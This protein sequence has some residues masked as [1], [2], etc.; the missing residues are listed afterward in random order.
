M[1]AFALEHHYDAV[2]LRCLDGKTVPP[3]LS[4]QERHRL[5]E[6]FRAVRIPIVCVGTS[7]RFASADVAERRQ[8]EHQVEQYIELASQWESP[9]VRVFGGHFPE[10]TTPEQAIQRVAESLSR[11]AP[12]AR[13]KGITLVLETHDGFSR[14]E[15]VYEVLKRVQDK[16]VRAC[17]DFLHPLRVGEPVE[18]TLALLKG[19]VAHTHAKD[20]RPTGEGVWIAT[21][22]GEGEIPF[23]QIVAGLAQSGFDGALSLEWE[24]R[25]GLAPEVVLAHYARKVRQYLPI[26][27]GEPGRL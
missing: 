25:N 8:N 6:T 12:K 24:G 4:A 9:L 14:G 5:Q 27:C 3:D 19:Y 2:E 1:A 16:N 23:G 26:G 15:Y 22:L 20:A 18:N 11:L 7:A 21:L 13:E 17:W 10:D